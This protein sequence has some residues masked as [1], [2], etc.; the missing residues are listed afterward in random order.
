M[1]R[2]SC[3]SGCSSR[4]PRSSTRSA[5][6]SG[7]TSWPSRTPRRSTCGP[8]SSA[9]RTPVELVILR[10]ARY[11]DEREEVD[12]GEI[13]VFVGDGLRHH[14]PAGRRQRAARR[15]AAS[16]VAPGAAARSAPL[17]AVGDPRPGRRRLRPGRRRAR[18]RHRGGREHRVR[19]RRSR[20]PSGS[21]SCAARS[22]TST[23]PCTRCS[24][25]WPRS[26]GRRA[27][28]TLLP[29]LRDV[30]DHLLLVNEEVSAQRDLLATVLE[31][32]M[33]VISV[34]QTEVRS[35][36]APPWSG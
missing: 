11:D 31:A 23:A 26:S 5:G 15:A 32:N 21:T 1:S 24:P 28:A 10:T 36:R 13:S 9:T 25:S 20:R 16:R 19:R 29:Y 12:F 30:H 3:G 35:G 34:E 14:R 4:A 22:P 17:D 7:C 6:P 8:R 2:A 18:A 27:T 33:A